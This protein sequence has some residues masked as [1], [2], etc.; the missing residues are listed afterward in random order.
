MYSD[1]NELITYSVNKK[2]KF[3]N[4]NKVKY[5]T[6]SILAGIYVGLS[7]LFIYTIGGYTE[8]IEINK[9]IMGASFG[10][11]LSL[12]MMLGS[13]LFTGN[14]MVGFGGF[15]NGVVT[16]KNMLKL[17]CFSW[18]GNF[19]GSVALSF[20]YVYSNTGGEHIKHF[21]IKSALFKASFSP[22]E[23]F[24]KGLLCNILV[25]LAVISAYK[26]KEETSKLIMIFWCL[27]AFITTGYEHSVANMTLMTT[28]VLLKGMSLS[29]MFY[30]LLF[31]TLGNITGGSLLALSYFILKNNNDVN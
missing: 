9:V 26:L 15:L 22:I 27:F 3:L 16:F 20:I 1:L 19:I 2:I 28:A 5:F 6:A 8:N 30:N 31:V 17:W 21:I 29:G 10:I 11:S 23:L 13:E 4:E 7:I 12:V 24:L 14:N 18:I 25:C